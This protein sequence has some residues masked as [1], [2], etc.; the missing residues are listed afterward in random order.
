MRADHY[1]VRVISA[2]KVGNCRMRTITRFLT[3]VG[4]ST[5]LLFSALAPSFAGSEGRRNTAIVLTAATIYQA[6]HNKDGS[7]AVLGLAS[8]LA[9]KSYEDARMDESRYRWGYYRS[10]YSRPGHSNSSYS[11][12]RYRDYEH[13][14]DRRDDYGRSKDGRSDRGKSQPRGNAY[15]HYKN[16]R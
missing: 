10:G 11:S 13:S 6:T 9:W 1:F 16:R 5:A 3:V 12:N 7:A 14:N 8:A 2:R 4:V 15:G